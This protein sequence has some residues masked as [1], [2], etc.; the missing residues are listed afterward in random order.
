MH[1][2]GWQASEMKCRLIVVEPH[3]AGSWGSHGASAG[4]GKGFRAMGFYEDGT[5]VRQARVGEDSAI[6]V[7]GSSGELKRTQCASRVKDEAT[8]YIH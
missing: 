5:G 8:P 7:Q 6:S 4:A 3:A 1:G 2:S